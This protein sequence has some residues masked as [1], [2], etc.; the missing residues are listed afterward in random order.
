MD[1]VSDSSFEQAYRFQN[2]Q[3]AGD[4]N[5]AVRFFYDE[6]EDDA[7]TKA[8]GHPV[9]KSVEMCEIC[10]PGDKDNTIVGRLKSMHPDPR[11]RFPAA[12]AKFKRGEKVQIAGY[13]LREWGLITRA[14]AKEYEALNIMTVEQ[15]ASLSDT[16]AANIRGSLAERQKAADFLEFS[17]G[18]APLAQARAEMDAQKSE[19]E[20]LKEML[21]QQGKRIEELSAKGKGK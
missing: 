1:D 6:I 4:R 17:K 21:A 8:E 5:L 3:A 19:I 18:Q 15:L 12:Y 20:T 9:F 11:E 16:N 10:V 14:R 2:D 13:L 7:A